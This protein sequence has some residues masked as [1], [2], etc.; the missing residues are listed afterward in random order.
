M[1][2]LIIALSLLNAL[3]II[4][5]VVTWRVMAVRLSDVETRIT[6]LEHESAAADA[7]SAGGSASGADDRDDSLKWK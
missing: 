5:M 4:F 1:N 3:L 2:A 7:R 6:E